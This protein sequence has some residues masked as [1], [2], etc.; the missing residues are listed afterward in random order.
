MKSYYKYLVV[1][2]FMLFSMAS[3]AQDQNP[4]ATYVENEF[5]IWLE[6]GVDA[7]TFAIQSNAGIIPK[8]MLSQRLNIWLFE[9]DD[10]AESHEAKMERLW[11]NPDVRVI[12]NN[13]TNISLRAARPPLRGRASPRDPPS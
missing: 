1:I 6:Q 2:A 9:I 5:I 13:H 8:R 11:K 7:S 12:Q 4:Q 3:F 10:K